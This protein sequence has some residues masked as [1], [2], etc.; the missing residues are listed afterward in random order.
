MLVFERRSWWESHVTEWTNQR[1]ETSHTQEVTSEQVSSG[2]CSARTIRSKLWT[3]VR[4]TPWCL[5]IR[6]QSDSTRRLGDNTPQSLSQRLEETRRST[7]KLQL[8]FTK[9]LRRLN[10]RQVYRMMCCL[11]DRITWLSITCSTSFSETH[12]G[13][14]RRLMCRNNNYRCSV[15]H[16]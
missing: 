9:H 7:R 8:N 16:C 11:C 10:V 13:L 1:A 15:W 3:E 6:L 4:W 5:F 12:E 14:M 2:V